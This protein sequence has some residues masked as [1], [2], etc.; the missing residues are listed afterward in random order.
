[1][2]DGR[3]CFGGE[4]AE[5]SDCVELEVLMVYPSRDRNTRLQIIKGCG[6][7]REKCVS[8]TQERWLRPV[9]KRH[10]RYIVYTRPLEKELIVL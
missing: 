7:E 1:M 8:T 9:C 4:D 6:L 3:K 5:H 10:H 2:Q